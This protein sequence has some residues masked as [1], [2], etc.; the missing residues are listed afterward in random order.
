MVN[1]ESSNYWYWF[2]KGSGGKPG[3]RRI[4]N[5][6]IMIHLLIGFALAVL[7]KTNLSVSANSVLLPL[8]GILVG[9]TFAW[10]GN[11]QALIRSG[12]IGKLSEYH[13][14]GFIEYVY[15]YQ[16]AILIILVTLV[17]WGFA[18]LGIFDQYWPKWWPNS[19]AVDSYFIVKSILFTFASL[20]IR[21]CWQVVMGVQLMLIAQKKIKEHFERM[22]THK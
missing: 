13:E 7:V 16:T 8:A 21:V 22:N 17:F 15:L 18:G 1:Q 12:E 2:F 9:L 5:R 6:W 19:L 3:Y 11:A 4:V 10:A 14:G 20:T